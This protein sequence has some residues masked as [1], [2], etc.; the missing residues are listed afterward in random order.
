[1]DDQSIVYLVEDKPVRKNIFWHC[2]V[3]SYGKIFKSTN[4]RVNWR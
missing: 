4:G 2:G 3:V 1:M